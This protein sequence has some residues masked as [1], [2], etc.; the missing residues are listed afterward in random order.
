MTGALSNIIQ[1][2]SHK[3]VHDCLELETTCSNEEHS[4][5][6]IRL[7]VCFNSNFLTLCV[8]KNQNNL[9]YIIIMYGTFILSAYL[10]F[11]FFKFGNINQLIRLWYLSHRQT[12]KAQAR[13][14]I[15]T[16][17]PEPSLFAHITYGSRR[18]V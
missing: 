14:H 5:V 6:G 1:K 16:V 13:L 15:C 7:I 11:F 8:L 18:R 9:Q 12:A 2:I 17:S 10:V 3:I 4:R